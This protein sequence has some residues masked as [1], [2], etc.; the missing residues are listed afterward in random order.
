MIRNIGG[1]VGRRRTMQLSMFHL[2][3]AGCAEGLSRCDR[4]GVLS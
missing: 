1:G 3:M 2:L 4:K